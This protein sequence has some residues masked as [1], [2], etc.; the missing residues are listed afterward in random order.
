MIRKKIIVKNSD[1][2]IMM[3]VA[4]FLLFFPIILLNG[5]NSTKIRKIT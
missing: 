4:N 3:V 5:Y 1:Y 2:D